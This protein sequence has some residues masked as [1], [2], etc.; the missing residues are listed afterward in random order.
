ML[1]SKMSYLAD[2]RHAYRQG[3][4]YMSHSLVA[5]HPLRSDPRIAPDVS[6]GKYLPTTRYHRLEKGLY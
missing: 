5:E 6:Y 4:V 2:L 3:T 1:S